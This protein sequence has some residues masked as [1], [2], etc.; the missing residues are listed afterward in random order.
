MRITR[1]THGR[2]V[3][4]SY[5]QQ[6]GDVTSWAIEERSPNITPDIQSDINEI[7]TE[8]QQDQTNPTE[9]ERIEANAST[10]DK[11]IED[12]EDLEEETKVEDKWALYEMYL[13]GFVEWTGG[14]VL[15]DAAKN[16][17]NGLDD[18]WK[19]SLAQALIQ[20]HNNGEW[21]LWNYTTSELGQKINILKTA[22]ESLGIT[23]ETAKEI[24]KY[25]LKE[26]YC[27]KGKYIDH[28]IK[29]DS[30]EGLQYWNALPEWLFPA[31]RSDTKFGWLEVN[32]LSRF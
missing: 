29:V 10:T 11:L 25:A 17:I 7:D 20:A 31:I 9:K 15:S 26:G 8:R 27:G 16:A 28:I 22:L 12:L 19:A 4:D 18:M 24:Y 6:K 2:S 13:E 5:K 3:C 32:W 1:S 21:G 14:L 30:I 23:G